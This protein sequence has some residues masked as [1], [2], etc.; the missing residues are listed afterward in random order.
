MA[1]KRTDGG[2]VIVG[3]VLIAVGAYALLGQQV[4][5]SPIAPREDG[6]FGGWFATVV[7]IVMI[8][9]GLYFLRESRK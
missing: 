7:G 2:L 5:F 4:H 6:G 3:L 1:N 9:G 8:L